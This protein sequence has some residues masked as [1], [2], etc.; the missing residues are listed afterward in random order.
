MYGHFIGYLLLCWV[1]SPLIAMISRCFKRILMDLDIFLHTVRENVGPVELKKMEG[2]MN[3]GLKIDI[4]KS[5]GMEW[6]WI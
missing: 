1:W 2:G 3:I 6:I 4:A 5:L